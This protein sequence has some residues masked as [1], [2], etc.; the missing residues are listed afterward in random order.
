M[1]FIAFIKHGADFGPVELLF[2]ESL[3]KDCVTLQRRDDKELWLTTPK[4]RNFTSHLYDKSIDI[5][6]SEDVSAVYLTELGD[7]LEK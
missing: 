6:I 1:A 5:R 2:Q 4:D 7:L 3:E